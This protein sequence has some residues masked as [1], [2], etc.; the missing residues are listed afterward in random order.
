MSEREKYISYSNVY[1]W[2]LEK[3]YQR[4][5]L[6]GRNGETDIEHR[7]MDMGA[8]EEGED[9]I[10]GESNMEIYNTIYKTDSQWE[11]AVCLRELKPTW[12]L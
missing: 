9:E 12:V 10:Y 6:Q 5:Y 7:P 8:A 3:W 2:N 11:F 1:V 4:I